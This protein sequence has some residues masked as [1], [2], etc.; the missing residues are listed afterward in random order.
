MMP[1]NDGT[2][3]GKIKAYIEMLAQFG[4]VYP[5]MEEVDGQFVCK[6]PQVEYPREYSRNDGTQEV[7]IYAAGFSMVYDE[8]TSMPV[9]TL[10]TAVEVTKV[11]FKTYPVVTIAEEALNQTVASAAGT[12]TIDC[13]LEN[14]IAGTEWGFDI[15]ADW[16][17]A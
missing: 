14:A 13:K 8:A 12:T 5:E 16:L 7:E 17:S 11:P 2:N 4:M 6:G 10:L 9:V 3:E 15:S 1:E